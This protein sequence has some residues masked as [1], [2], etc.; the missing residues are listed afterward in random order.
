MYADGICGE[1]GEW[2]EEARST[3]GGMLDD[4]HG[5]DSLD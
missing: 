3:G 4:I 2:G 5:E 1:R